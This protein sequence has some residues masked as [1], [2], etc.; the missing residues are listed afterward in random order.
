V[1]GRVGETCWHP[2]EQ[3]I[4]QAGG[5]LLWRARIAEPQEKPPWI[6][7]WGADVEVVEPLNLR[8]RL[9]GEAR[10]LAEGY[11]W[12]VSRGDGMEDDTLGRTFADYFG[13]AL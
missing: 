10:R 13:G 11:G 8:E 3:V 9:S 5:S 6:R 4:E 2:S 7:G 1:A 12:Q